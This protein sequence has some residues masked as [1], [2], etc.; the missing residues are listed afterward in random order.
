MINKKT[1]LEAK[2]S[3]WDSALYLKYK[4][5]RTQPSYDL[6]ARLPRNGIN[7]IL[8]LGC[9]PGNSTAVLAEVYPR[10]D[11]LGVD[12]SE[13]MIDCARSEY[14]QLNWQVCLAP[15]GLDALPHNFDLV[16]SNACIQWIPDHA[17][18]IPALLKLLVPGGTLA[19]QMPMNL[20]E[21]VQQIIEKTV[22]SE[23]WN[24]YFPHPRVFYTLRPEEY[25]ELLS[26][27]SSGFTMWQVVYY[28]MMDSALDL[29][30]WY[31]GTGL[32]PYL[33]QLDAK[34]IPSFEADILAQYEA[35]YPKQKNG[36]II[37]RFPRFFFTAVK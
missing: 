10:A 32:R 7:R 14:P 19:V 28:Y 3:D 9:G 37:Y 30:D 34:D 18:L 11:I 2:M 16:F 27:I 23:K 35:A 36:K 5:E 31:R 25:Q 24:S 1:D 33:S 13:N 12:G 22:R 29:L 8:D 26:G 20:N 15:D 4:T 21:S 17:T 6:A